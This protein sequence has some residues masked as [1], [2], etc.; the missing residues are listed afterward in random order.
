V[1]GQRQEIKELNDQLGILTID[2]PGRIHVI[3]HYADRSEAWH[4]DLPLRF[5]WE[6]YLPPKAYLLRWRIG[7]IPITGLPVESSSEQLLD[8]G[9][10]SRYVVQVDFS[11]SRTRGWMMKLTHAT[12]ESTYFIPDSES[13]WLNVPT[14]LAW[15][16]AGGKLVGALGATT[17]TESF[18]ADERIVLLRCRP[19][20]SGAKEVIN[21]PARFSAQGSGGG[22]GSP[23]TT[24]P[25]NAPLADGI[26]VWLE[27]V[28]DSGVR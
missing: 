27:P 7:S 14:P 9:L 15:E 26:M 23:G 16:G 18:S 28:S 4:G 19:E 11:N 21:V 1:A 8:P 5:G 20:F 2:D 17:E 10:D 24:A 12:N 3:A 6:I 25:N 13:V 22:F